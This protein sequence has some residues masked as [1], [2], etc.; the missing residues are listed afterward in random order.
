VD[1]THEAAMFVLQVGVVLV[2]AKVGGEIFERWLRQPA[3]LG[4]LLMGVLIGPYAL[5][6]IDVPGVGR[7]FGEAT[8][9]GEIPIPLALWVFAELGAVVL[10]FVA[11]LET[12]FESF[13][14]FGPTATV[15]AIGGVILPFIFGMVATVALG[16]AP[17]LASPE[18]LFT[19]AALTATS[20]G[21][22]ARVLGDIGE[23]DT[24]EGITILGA[25][26][27]DDVI[28]IL[29]LAVVVAIAQSGSVDALQLGLIGG[30]A[31]VAYFILTAVLVL[32]AR[33]IAAAFNAFRSAGAGLALALALGFVSGFIAQ[34]VGLAMIVGAFSAGIALS[35]SNLRE[36]LGHDMRAVSHVVVPVFFVIVGMLVNLP[37]LGSVLLF[38]TIV[39]ALAIVGKIVGCSLPALA[40]GFTPIG[41]LRVG[42]GMIPRGEVALIIAGIGLTTGAVGQSLFA[43]VVF[44][45]FATTVLAPIFLVPS[46]RRGGAGFRGEAPATT[47][48]TFDLTLPADLLDPFSRHLL[49]ALTARGFVVV[50][51]VAEEHFLELRRGDQLMVIAT[52]IEGPGLRRMHVE[53]EGAIPDWSE[54]LADAAGRS[55][56][57]LSRALAPALGPAAS[58]R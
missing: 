47:P 12:D 16:L 34:S 28:G 52:H 9:G 56:A 3:V 42:V 55:Q 46:F 48:L 40:L 41:A 26:V 7:L 50:G 25:A 44:M 19:G 21:V 27:F 24:P 29:V 38:G 5:G 1:L 14:R 58:Q 51:A 18:A 32:A 36:R 17:S 22:T 53:S 2:A 6:A 4:E 8:A 54:A 10:L 37:A 31:L 39:S 30:K 49:A 57:E 35:R 11:G 15:V 33:R 45:T 23:L 43:V 13:V 20:V